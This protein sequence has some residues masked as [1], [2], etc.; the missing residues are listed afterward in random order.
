MT[1][2]PNELVFQ[3]AIDTGLQRRFKWKSNSNLTDFPPVSVTEI[4]RSGCYYKKP[5][6]A[7]YFLLV[8]LRTTET[9]KQTNILLIGSFQSP[10]SMAVV[11]CLFLCRDCVMCVLQTDWGY[12]RTWQINTDARRYWH[13]VTS[14]TTAKVTWHFLDF[15]CHSFGPRPA[16]LPLLIVMM[17]AYF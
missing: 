13:R 8:K 1:L 3:P 9:S 10:S 12:R 5:I 7:I 16:V 4:N 17:R 14:K 15:Y 11:L 2:K 6:S